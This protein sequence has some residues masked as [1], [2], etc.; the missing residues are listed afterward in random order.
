MVSLLKWVVPF[1]I[2]LIGSLIAVF[3]EYHTT[4]AKV[5]VI[6]SV[7]GIVICLLSLTGFSMRGSGMSCVDQR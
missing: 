6:V 7:I 4:I 5:G 3:F 1:N 2:L